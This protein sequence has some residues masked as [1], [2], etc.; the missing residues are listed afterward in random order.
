MMIT[1]KLMRSVGL[2]NKSEDFEVL[3]LFHLK[4]Q[5]YLIEDLIAGFVCHLLVKLLLS[6]QWMH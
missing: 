6:L 5:W 2:L 1:V 3:L 4:V